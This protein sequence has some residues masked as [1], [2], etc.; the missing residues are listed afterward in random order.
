MS[1]DIDRALDRAQ[2]LLAHL[3]D[4]RRDGHTLRTEIEDEFGDDGEALSTDAQET[5]AEMRRVL[6]PTY[7]VE[8]TGNGNTEA[9]GTSYS[10][11]AITWEGAEGSAP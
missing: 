11:V 5:I 9:D 7:S 6:G 4:T 8:W 1:S 2:S 10:D 3:I